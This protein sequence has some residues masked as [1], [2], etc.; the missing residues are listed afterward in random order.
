FSTQRSSSPA[1]ITSNFI[2]NSFFLSYDFQTVQATKKLQQKRCPI[3]CRSPLRTCYSKS[4]SSSS[5]ALRKPP[6]VVLFP[7][8]F[9]LLFRVW[10]FCALVLLFLDCCS[11]LSWQF[12]PA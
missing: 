2:K 9:V 6:D 5:Y 12:S 1:E 3:F 4:E 11:A 8:L 10:E 7:A